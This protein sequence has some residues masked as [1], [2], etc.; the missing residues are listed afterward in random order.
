MELALSDADVTRL[1]ETQK[2]A[3]LAA[4]FTALIAD[5]S[6]R[7]EELA[8]FDEAVGK[9]PWGRSAEQ[10]KAKTTAVAGRITGADRDGKLAFVAE[11]AAALPEPA[12]RE[13]VVLSML[14]IVSADKQM[15]PG[16]RASLSSFLRVFG[17]DDAQ[18]AKLRERIASDGV[19]RS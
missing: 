1:D 14:A 15:S 4:L 9:L 10:I 12:L 16:E 13:K 19:A 7:P 2:D 11:V 17:F 3:V 8:K 6:P 5:G 18:V